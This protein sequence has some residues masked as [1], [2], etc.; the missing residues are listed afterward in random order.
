MKCW[1]E[2]LPTEEDSSSSE[3]G[4]VKSSSEQSVAIK[5]TIIKPEK[6]YVISRSFQLPLNNP[7]ALRTLLY[8]LKN[9]SKS[10]VVR[11]LH[12]GDSQLEGDRITDYFRN[13]IQKRFGGKG[14]RGFCYLMS[15]QHLRE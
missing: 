2:Y 5:D 3:N 12:Y 10:K 9:E 8:G 11:I 1:Q 14:A 4:E 7:E 6:K 13:K 15:Q